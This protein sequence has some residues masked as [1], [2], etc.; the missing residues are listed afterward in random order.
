MNRV[1]IVFHNKEACLE[2]PITFEEAK[3]LRA[4][5]APSVVSHIYGRFSDLITIFVTSWDWFS[6]VL[7]IESCYG[8]NNMANATIT[9]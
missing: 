4:L 1:K 3:R 5:L 2:R 8:A 6:N 9:A 7:H